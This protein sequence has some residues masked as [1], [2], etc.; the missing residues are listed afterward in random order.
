MDGLFNYEF[1]YA[2][3]IEKLK[4]DEPLAF[5]RFGDSE[6]KCI[7]D[8]GGNHCDGLHHYTDCGVELKNLLKRNPDYI[9]GMQPFSTRM[10][11]DKIA[12]F[13]KLENIDVKWCNA[14]ILHKASIKKQ[15][16][17]LF[18][19]YDNHHLI[20]VA[21]E[22][23]KKCDQ[24]FSIEQW[25]DVPTNECW[26]SRKQVTY[27][28]AKCLERKKGIYKIV[29][30]QSAMLSNIMLDEFYGRY[31]H[32]TA[33]VDAGSIFEPYCGVLSRTYHKNLGITKIIT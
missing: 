13:L 6:W 15:L 28:L 12:E 27:D 33:F 8:M 9:C 25:V 21:P 18:V 32:N 30:L 3:L 17:E 26:L 1:T 5:M 11:G 7:F 2:D 14:D 23:L 20:M 19:Q 24:L 29:S 16:G 10:F 4:N 31:G 22:H